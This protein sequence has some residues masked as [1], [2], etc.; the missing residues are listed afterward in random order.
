MREEVTRVNIFLPSSGG[1]W[2]ETNGDCHSDRL[3]EGMGNDRRKWGLSSSHV[4]YWALVEALFALE[5]ALEFIS[6]PK[7]EHQ[8]GSLDHIQLFKFLNT[9]IIFLL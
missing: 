1:H 2:P 8:L 5:R 6:L 7:L 3:E 9:H 4:V